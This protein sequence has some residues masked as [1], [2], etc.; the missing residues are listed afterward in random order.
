MSSSD[1]SSLSP[2]VSL[3]LS[4]E[5]NR[6]SSAWQKVDEAHSN[7]QTQNDSNQANEST[8]TKADEP[9]EPV[10]SISSSLT[11]SAES[12]LSHFLHSALSL[13]QLS[14]LSLAPPFPISSLIQS[15]GLDCS[16][17]LIFF[18]SRYREFS[19]SSSLFSALQRERHEWNQIERQIYLKSAVKSSELQEISHF[20]SSESGLFYPISVALTREKLIILLSLCPGLSIL[21]SH[22]Y[23]CYTHKLM[24][25]DSSTL[26]YM[27]F[28]LEQRRL[29]DKR[30]KREIR[31]YLLS[32]SINT[33][34]SRNTYLIIIHYFFVDHF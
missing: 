20:L 22:L 25:Y 19:S 26:N 4:L 32:H 8:K 11:S 18:L 30:N 27:I 21:K 29:R 31:K 3:L 10:T 23:E 2:L 33:S 1:S 5:S 28:Q 7:N 16:L 12:S 14:S 34:N 9:P 13:R 24:I 6:K 17:F 15:G